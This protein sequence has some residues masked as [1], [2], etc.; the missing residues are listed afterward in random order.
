MVEEEP[1]VKPGRASRDSSTEAAR[2]IVA[3]E[4]SVYLRGRVERAA[5]PTLVELRRHFESL[6]AEV[7]GQS[8]LDASEATRRLINRLLHGPSET[9]RRAAAEDAES[10][11][12]LET[13]LWE[14]FGRAQGPPAPPDDEESDEE[15]DRA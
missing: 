6:R 2:A 12:R 1:Q 4:L 14:L 11:V 5:V 15:E 10:R 9:L 7:L 13:A 3:E 8:G